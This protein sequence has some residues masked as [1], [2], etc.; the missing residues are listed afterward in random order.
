MDN[1]ADTRAWIIYS[2]DVPTSSPGYKAIHENLVAHNRM[3]IPAAN[4]H[5][6]PYRRSGG[7]G[8]TDKLVVDW[9]PK[10]DGSGAALQVYIRSDT[11]AFIGNYDCNG[12]PISGGRKLKERASGCKKEKATKSPK[13]WLAHH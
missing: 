3:N 12:K 1:V 4:V 11:P 13:L 7:G 2:D 9:A 10:R 6:V 8:T 5:N